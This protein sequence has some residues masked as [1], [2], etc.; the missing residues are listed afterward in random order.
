MHAPQPKLYRYLWPARGTGEPRPE[1][2]VLSNHVTPAEIEAG[3][4]VVRDQGRAGYSYFESVP[5]FWRWFAGEPPAARTAQEVCFGARR[6]VFDIDAEPGALEKVA[7]S[8][9]DRRAIFPG[10]GQPAPGAPLEEIA[11]AALLYLTRLIADVFEARY[12]GETL[13]PAD[14]LVSA[15]SRPRATDKY[16]YHILVLPFLVADAYE[17]RAFTSALLAELR[18]TPALHALVDP[19]VNATTQCF[20]LTGAQKQGTDRVKGHPPELAARLG[21]RALTGPLERTGPASMVSKAPGARLL[22]RL[23]DP[24]HPPAAREALTDDDENRILERV[25]AAGVASGHVFRRRLGTVFTYDRTQPTHCRVC[26]RTHDKDN[27][28]VVVAEP[29]PTAT[30]VHLREH[31]RRAADPAAGI[32]LGEVECSPGAFE[33]PAASA[34]AP[35]LRAAASRVRGVVAGLQEG[36]RDP[37]AAA[38][39]LFE[40]LPPAQREVYSAPAMRP[41]AA[42]ETLVV[43]A[44]MGVG[45]TKELA[46]YL[47]RL[48]PPPGSL[49][50]RPVVRFLTF[51]QTFSRSLKNHFPDFRLYTDNLP[52]Q[53]TPAAAPRLIIQVESLHRLMSEAAAGVPVDLLILDEVE[54]VLAQFSSGLHKSFGDAFTVFQWLLATA[55]RVVCMDANVSDRT[56]RVLE[57]FRPGRPPHFHWNTH[58]RAAGDTVRVTTARDDWL[59]HLTAALAAGK[60]VAFASNSLREAKAVVRLVREA[61]P[62]K[63]VA[64]YS[65]ETPQGVKELH[66]ADV[67]TYWSQY[68]MVAYTPTVSA[69]VSYERAHFDCM[70]VYLSDLSCDVETARQMLGRVRNLRDREYNVCFRSLGGAH[71]TDLATLERLVYDRRE[72]YAGGPGKGGAPPANEFDPATGTVRPYRSAYFYLWL[73][74]R[75]IENLSRNG[76]ADRFLD[77]VAETGARVEYLES[78]GGDCKAAARGAREAAGRSVDA[79]EAQAVA[80]AAEL[81]YGEVADIRRR[82]SAQVEVTPDERAALRKFNLRTRYNWTGAIDAPFVRDLAPPKVQNWYVNLEYVF[83]HPSLAAALAQLW[84]TERQSHQAID[85][86]AAAPGVSQ[87]RGGGARDLLELLEHRALHRRD[88]YPAHHFALWFL[89]VCGFRCLSDPA[90]VLGS[91]AYGRLAAARTAARRDL[92]LIVQ[93]FE[94]RHPDRRALEAGGGGEEGRLACARALLNMANAA[95]RKTYGYEIR[96]VPRV[97]EL[98]YRLERLEASRVFGGTGRPAFPVRLV[99][100]DLRRDAELLFAAWAYFEYLTHPAE[101]DPPAAAAELN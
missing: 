47:A 49:E 32:D 59:A 4:L 65:S 100:P 93:E 2:E 57:R 53:I 92:A 36:R 73:E 78:L 48:E 58:A 3:G 12:P 82:L 22:P 77:Q 69:G 98:A 11:V 21:T 41:Y 52:A 30:Q 24:V 67:D 28:L 81:D 19:R 62:A 40:A 37:R 72:L 61:H 55:A 54:S 18:E 9:R 26:D 27:T 97:A 16:S 45:K 8:E 86:A 89:R 94:I 1:S 84:A 80:S 25:R 15:S 29:G 91:W 5:A 13:D 38:D 63:Q 51:R 60:K 71:P 87:K 74:T 7:H 44:Q 39:H 68:D 99:P 42:A 70:Y 76:Y 88:R 75:R 66:F 34:T 33:R 83:Q 6:L 95:L 90:P 64:L 43:K 20:R 96:R 46:A 31:C 35:Q 10:G 101:G 56:Y 50:P 85:A 17:A 79:E 23:V 14:M